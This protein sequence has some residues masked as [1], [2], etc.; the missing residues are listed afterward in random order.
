MQMNSGV[1]IADR[2]ANHC[3]LILGNIFLTYTVGVA[4]DANINSLVTNLE[5][6]LNLLPARTKG[7]Y[8][9]VT[10]K[11]TRPPEGQARKLV[12]EVFARHSAKLGAVAI[13]VESTGFSS[14]ILRAVASSLFLLS[15][16]N[17]PVKFFSQYADAVPWICDSTAAR[18][19]DL[20]RLLRRARE[21][22]KAD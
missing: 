13:V 21:L 12:E 16:R 17:L 14:A 18:S 2:D 8:V 22:V 19:E 9:L 7:G 15:Q 1:A 4:S 3:Q 10:T 20:E 6:F 11:T 5:R